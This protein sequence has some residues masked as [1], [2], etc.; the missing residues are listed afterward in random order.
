[1]V[2]YNFAR[3]LPIPAAGVRIVPETLSILLVDD[4]EDT[5]RSLVLL[6]RRRGYR[7]ESALDMAAAAALAD[8]QPFDVLVSDL[9]LPDGSGIDLLRRLKVYPPRYGGIIVSGYGMDDDVERSQA[10]GYKAHLTKPVEVQRLDEE[11]QRLVRES[12]APS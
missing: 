1:M 8:A 9:N 7:V 3:V 2:R 11:I 4:H 5:N 12:G 10:A 6:L